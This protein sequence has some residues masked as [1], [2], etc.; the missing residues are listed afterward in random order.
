LLEL[1]ADDGEGVG[2]DRQVEGVIATGAPLG[3]QLLQCLGEPL[4]TLGVIEGALREANSF[5]EPVP[6]FLAERRPSVISN[7]FVDQLG[8]IFVRPVA[9]CETDQCE[10]RRKQPA[11]SQV[12]Y[13]GHQLLACEVACDTEDDDRTRARDM[14]HPLVA[15]VAQRITPRAHF[16][17]SS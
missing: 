8:E 11:I 16:L 5:G 1:F 6:N 12:I 4:V 14:G 17:A 13:R 3:V 7:R 2:R 10:I 15:L 9:T